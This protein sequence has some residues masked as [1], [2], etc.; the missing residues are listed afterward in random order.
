[1]NKLR[2]RSDF[3]N[4]AAISHARAIDVR[5]E[6]ADLLTDLEAMPL[7]SLMERAVAGRRRHHREFISYSRKVFIP[8]TRLCRDVCGYC[9]FATTPVKLESAYLSPE[10]VL[11]IALAGERAGCREALF[12][13]GDK[14]ELRYAAARDALS[15]LGYESTMQYLFA[16]CELVLRET[17]LLPHVNAGIMTED[18]IDAFRAVSVSQGI[19]LESVSRRLCERGGPHYGSPDK[20]PA[21]RL[22]MIAAAGR[23]RVPFTSGI[24]IGIGE[25]RL[26]RI[27]SLIALRDLHRAHGHIQEV[28]V[29][30]F[31][32]KDSTRMAESDEPD[33]D[34]LKWTAAAARLILGDAANIQVPPNLS[35][36]DFPALLDA[37]INDWGGISPVTPDHVNPEAPWPQI[38]S[39][40]A[41]TASRGATLVQRL[42]VYPDYALQPEIWQ[43]KDLASRVLSEIDADGLARDST[44][45]VGLD[46]PPPSK[47]VPI[48]VR[49]HGP[50][51]DRIISR[52]TAGS[53]LDEDEIV[54]LFSARD[55]ALDEVCDAAD[56]LRKAV[57]GDVVRYVVNRNINYTNV[58]TYR[59]QFCA[60]SKG[61]L[62]ESLRGPAYDLSFD[63]I[64]RRVTEAWD[65]GA[66][67]VCMQGGIN[68]HYTGQT[69]L[70][71][72]RTVK[73]A[74]RGM[75]VHAFSPLEVSQGAATLG[76]PV[77]RFLEQLRDAGLGT[78]PGTA[79]EILDDEVRAIICAD[80]LSTAEWISVVEAAHRVGLKTTSTI[81][82]GHIERP[83]AWARHLLHLR[84]LQQRTGGLTEFV[85]LPFVHMEAPI[86]LRGKARK[87]PTWRESLLMHAVPRLVLHPLIANIQT[88]WVKLGPAGAAQAL[89]AGA[90]DLGGTLMNESIS[91]AA[92][93]QHGQEFSP[94]EMERLVAGLGRVPQ[95]R[96]TLYEDV[97][98]E[99]R[100]RSF[101]S[102]PLQ[103]PIFTPFKRKLVS[104][105]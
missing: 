92:G 1:M 2:Q 74:Q 31:R 24:L 72:V 13:L 42:A 54:Q 84:D 61:K 37:G 4:V 9:T 87:G 41:A 6:A 62:G 86:F 56:G 26:E 85:P 50:A 19:M 66:T 51:L 18:E 97:N 36:A 46:E 65:R 20:D 99:R 10:Q 83:R 93:T 91:R 14:P 98:A 43:H 47:S 55:T 53:R 7:A 25:T 3:E 89:Q 100:M 30:N 34:D 38:A 90:N 11:A 63:E 58:C 103:D 32:A 60:F 102:T 81:M 44:W 35:Y 70:D 28:I 59:C 40:G 77:T 45:A 69:Y 76:I 64:A 57:S 8:L 16:M 21:H 79:A 94:E 68:P 23:K 71:I 73:A 22:D 80:K 88:S 39:L 49:S 95:Q 75:H 52:A 5:Q 15:R 78:L 29:Q 67:E 33:I 101:G 105:I 96:T 104:V 27:L 12:T 82:F 17:S 48:F